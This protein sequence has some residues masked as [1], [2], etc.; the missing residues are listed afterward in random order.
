MA[1]TFTALNRT[2]WRE[3]GCKDTKLFGYKRVL[4]GYFANHTRIG[5]GV[6]VAAIEKRKWGVA[7]WQ[8]PTLL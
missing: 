4:H 1:H 6:G 8:R 5:F 2:S 3:L 7:Y